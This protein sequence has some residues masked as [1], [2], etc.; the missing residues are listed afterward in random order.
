MTLVAV[1]FQ[2]DRFIALSDSRISGNVKI[3]DRFTKLRELRFHF[4]SGGTC[5]P[6]HEDHSGSLGFGYSGSTLFAMAF[7]STAENVLC[8]LHRQ[9]RISS[10]PNYLLILAVLRKI[11]QSMLPDILSKDHVFETVVFGFCPKEGTP[12]IFKQWFETSDDGL[13]TKDEETVATNNAL[14]N[15]GSGSSFFEELW[16]TRRKGDVFETMFDQ[17][18]AQSTDRGTGGN[19]QTLELDRK[20]VVRRGVRQSHS[21]EEDGFDFWGVDS[22]E[23]GEVGGYT[24]GRGYRFGLD[25]PNLLTHLH[26]R[27][28]GLD[29]FSKDLPQ[30]VTNAR[31]FSE[32][33]SYC[34]NIDEKL[35]LKGNYVIEN[36]ILL[37]GEYYFSKICP[38]CFLMA[39]LLHD[40]SR[41]NFRTP[42]TDAGTIEVPCVHC[43]KPI[44]MKSAEFVSQK[45]RAHV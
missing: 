42:C 35:H 24:L 34:I 30:G 45:Y 23:F 5:E 29:P 17:A 32:A 39:P 15:I 36:P 43:S 12:F 2:H 28:H 37:D 26:A 13:L 21:S 41:G 9:A 44:K 25:A 27:K 19:I 6:F 7:F 14:I 10:P 4:T 40:P 22:K 33:L 11:T 1:N 16:S 8:S 3:T 31:A 20:Q 38:S 18:V